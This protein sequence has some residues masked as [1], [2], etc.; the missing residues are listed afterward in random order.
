MS[1]HLLLAHQFPA[2]AE[3]E[4]KSELVLSISFF[5][6]RFAGL[7]AVLATKEK[8]AA[9]KEIM[10]KKNYSWTRAISY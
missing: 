5:D 7:Q 8:V 6:M 9:L 3:S 2:L 1:N 4:S 10:V